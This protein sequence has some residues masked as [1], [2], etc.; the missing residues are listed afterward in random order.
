MSKKRYD[1][2]SKEMYKPYPAMPDKKCCCDFST[3]V[4]LILIILQFSGKKYSS[5]GYSKASVVDNGI[6]F[7]IAIFFLYCCKPCK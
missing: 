1:Y 6:L 4:V 3:L 7:I 5:V 2:C